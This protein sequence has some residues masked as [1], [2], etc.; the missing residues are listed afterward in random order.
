[1]LDVV[2][3]TP[4]PELSATSPTSCA[5]LSRGAERSQV[6]DRQRASEDLSK[7]AEELRKQVQTAEADVERYRAEHDL[8][9]TPTGRLL[10]EQQ[11][12]DLS[13]QLGLIRA[14]IAD[15]QV[16]RRGGPRQE[17]GI[18]LE[19]LNEA[20]SSPTMTGLRALVRAGRAAGLRWRPSSGRATCTDP[21]AGTDARHQAADF[22]GTRPHRSGRPHRSRPRESSE[23]SL[24]RQSGD[25]RVSND[26]NNVALVE[27][28]D[29]ER[30]AEASRTVYQ[31]FL[32]RAKELGESQGIDS[33]NARVISP[34]PAAKPRI[35][36]RPR[37]SRRFAAVSASRSA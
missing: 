3:T 22:S 25:V 37:S 18:S 4:N 36:A 5:H 26:K 19:S 30:A 7:R 10:G 14:R 27:L 16:G 13:S 9:Q 28:R 34:A 11:I 21:G 6:R 17:G 2:V 1:M 8:V 23:L 35:G 20:L 24:Q 32:G 15:A 12:T 29:L 33:T 31:A